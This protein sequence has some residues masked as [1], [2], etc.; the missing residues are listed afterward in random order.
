M[1]IYQNP[2][3]FF[4]L[5]FFFV[6]KRKVLDIGFLVNSFFTIHTSIILIRKIFSGAG[7]QVGLNVLIDPE[8]DHYISYVR[9]FQGVQ[10]AI[11]HCKELTDLSNLVVGQPS[12]DV[13]IIVMPSVL[14]S[15]MEVFIS[16]KIVRFYLLI[17]SNILGSLF[18]CIK[19]EM[20]I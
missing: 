16:N 13:K 5:V 19:K 6:A 18:A 15:D 7:D 10:I 3:K 17:I 12:Y 9:S 14:T 1:N 4:I 11:H 8:V 20:H 2:K